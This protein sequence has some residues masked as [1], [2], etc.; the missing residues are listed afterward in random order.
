MSEHFSLNYFGSE[1]TATSLGL[2]SIPEQ[3][4]TITAHVIAM[5]DTGKMVAVD[6]TGR[7]TDVPGGHLDGGE[8]AVQAVI[9]ETFEE[10]KVT[11]DEP[12]L[13]DV[14]ELKSDDA[15]I[16]L[17]AKPYLLL[18]AATIDQVHTFEPTDE[19]S[20]RLFLTP[21]EFVEQYFADKKFAKLM[22][23]LA[24]VALSR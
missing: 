12:I 23:N 22:V 1:I 10:A 7:G 9:R 15:R 5:D 17:T 3:E 19:V 14:L 8:T 18:Y 4:R 6:I 24:N 16:G 21:D 2:S 11:I 13:I 20:R